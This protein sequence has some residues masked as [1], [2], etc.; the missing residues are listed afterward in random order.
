MGTFDHVVAGAL[1]IV[2]GP[3]Q[4]ITFVYQ[5]RGPYAGCWLLPGGKV[6]F[7]ESLEDT[8]RREALEET[9]CAVRSLRLTGVYELRGAWAEGAYHL[10]MFAFVADEATAAPTGFTGDHVGLVRQ[11]HLNELPIHSTD[12]RILTDA[13]IAKFQQHEIDAALKHDGI[14]MTSY[15]TP[16]GGG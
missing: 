5:E 7:G 14:T 1:V 8:A 2:P 6:E 11:A 15:H 4:T 12:M 10:L 13:G 3:R 16:N 9:G